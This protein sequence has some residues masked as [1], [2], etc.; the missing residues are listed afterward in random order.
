MVNEPFLTEMIV[1]LNVYVIFDKKN[2]Q[3]VSSTRC[4]NFTIIEQN[5]DCFCHIMVLLTTVLK[6][7]D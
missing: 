6:Q 3:N 4:K 2:L 1:L 5:S 7:L